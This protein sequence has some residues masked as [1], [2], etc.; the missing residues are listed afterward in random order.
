MPLKRIFNAVVR[1]LKIAAD[2]G[3]SS[4]L[5]GAL[6]RHRD[7]K[8]QTV[9]DIGA[10][11]GCWSERVLRFFPAANY[12]LVEAQKHVH[13]AG[14]NRLKERHPN[15]DYVLAAAGPRQGT[16]HFDGADPFGGQASDT[17]YPAHNIEVPVT[18]IDLELAR[19][20]WPGPFLLKLDTH[21]FEV[22]I[23]EG[24]TQ[25]LAHT[26]LIIVEVY[27]FQLMEGCLRF[28]EMCAFLEQ[29]GFRCL[30]IFDL[31]HRPGD[32]ALWQMDMLFAPKSRPEFQRST[33]L[34]PAA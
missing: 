28:H 3:R 17:P 24:A 16:I 13:G 12:L 33:Y 27:N 26:N 23:F 29:R 2:N 4:S 11:N 25:T 8:I 34:P 19:R 20:G 18:T 6:G 31:M 10:S 5:E 21:G 15:I 32:Q 1:R 7:I 22:P 30:D 14:L 9:V